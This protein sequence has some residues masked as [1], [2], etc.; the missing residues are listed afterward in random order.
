VASWWWG[1]GWLKGT[2]EGVQADWMRW[3]VSFVIWALYAIG[4]MA[5]FVLLYEL[6]QVLLW[7]TLIAL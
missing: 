4:L 7:I 1:A 6:A 3:G 2:L 5:Y